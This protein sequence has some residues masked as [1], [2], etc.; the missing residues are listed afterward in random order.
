MIIM[1]FKI[2]ILIVLFVYLIL[3]V[4]NI[5]KRDS[6]LLSERLFKF[7]KNLYYTILYGWMKFNYY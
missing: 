4:N 6:L 1:I 7:L 3:A 2:L 5:Q